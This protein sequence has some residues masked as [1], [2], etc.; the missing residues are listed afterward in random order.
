MS[1]EKQPGALGSETG[2]SLPRIKEIQEI[3]V[4]TFNGYYDTFTVTEQT[5]EEIKTRSSSN[6]LGE[7]KIAGLK[8]GA[9]LAG[10][11]PPIIAI[12]RN[13]RNGATGAEFDS[14]LT[15]AEHASVCAYS[16][17]RY[18]AKEAQGDW[19]LDLNSK[20]Q[21]RFYPVLDVIGNCKIL[22]HEGV[23]PFGYVVNLFFSQFCF[24]SVDSAL[25]FWVDNKVLY[26]EIKRTE[27]AYGTV[28]EKRLGVSFSDI[29]PAISLAP[30][31]DY[32]GDLD[33]LKYMAA[34]LINMCENLKHVYPDRSRTLSLAQTNFE[35]AVMW[36]QKDGSTSHN[37]WLV[38]SANGETLNKRK[39]GTAT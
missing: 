9:L 27:L 12:I 16:Q 10:D 36:A 13:D 24:P 2:A 28:G 14:A 3:I 37:T 39:D 6:V 30:Y 25:K 18:L 26:Q 19:V 5:E 21:K 31:T 7:F 32:F 29:P 23:S 22:C 33:P 38:P 4:K 15:P 20:S 11:G 35:Q 17:L 8:A 1:E 34:Q